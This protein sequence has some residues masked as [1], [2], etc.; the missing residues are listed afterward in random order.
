MVIKTLV[1]RQ[2]LL[3]VAKDLVGESEEKLER[4]AEFRLP[5]RVETSLGTDLNLFPYF[6]AI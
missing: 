2:S 3:S 4:Q 6:P 5:V 1:D